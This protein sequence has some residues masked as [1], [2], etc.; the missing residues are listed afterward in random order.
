MGAY[1]ILTFNDS[2][3]ALLVASL[4]ARWKDVVVAPGVRFESLRHPLNEDSSFEWMMA[5]RSSDSEAAG[6]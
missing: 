6:R 4:V 1:W 2:I 5:M 3:G